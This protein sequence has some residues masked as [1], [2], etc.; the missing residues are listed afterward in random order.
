MNVNALPE[1]QR[2]RLSY[3]QQ[4][5]ALMGNRLNRQKER[6]TYELDT[7]KVKLLLVDNNETFAQ[8]LPVLAADHVEI[9][10]F[11]LEWKPSYNGKSDIALIQLAVSTHI[12]VIDKLAPEI[13]VDMWRQLGNVLNRMDRIKIGFGCVEDV[14]KLGNDSALGLTK[15]TLAMIVDFALL[16]PILVDGYK[17][18]LQPMG[19]VNGKGLKDLT[20][21]FLNKN[22]DKRM[23]MSD[24]SIRPLREEQI[25]YAAID[26]YVLVH[27]FDEVRNRLWAKKVD[28]YDALEKYKRK[29]VKR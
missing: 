17:K 7:S 9:I 26:A 27:V 11:D 13:T 16:W 24:W 14:L 1:V 10:G 12:F 6:N 25:L 8:M 29:H 20:R 4:N 21:Q 3:A 2:N 15:A 28:I 19:Y 18:Q 22:I 5:Q 23:Q